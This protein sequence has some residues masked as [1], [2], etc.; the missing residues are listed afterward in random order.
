MNE[1]LVS[2]VIPTFNSEQYISECIDSV[3][4]QTHH[5]LEIIIVDDGS[6]DNTVNIVSDYK[7]DKIKF[8]SQINSGSAAA[9]NYGVLQATGIWLAFIDSDDIWLP[10]KLQKQLEFCSNQLWSHTDLY[11]LGDVYPEHTRT[12]Q[13]TEK[14]SGMIFENLLVEN[15]IATSCVLIKKEIF[16]EFGGFN[17]NYRAL[18][19]WDLWL[20]VSAKY[21]VCYHDEPLVY[22]RV[23][24]GSV[25][26][27]A[28][29]T[30]P[31]HLAL[32]NRVFS[33]Q[34]TTLHL[35]QLKNKALSRSCFICSQI[36]EQEEDYPF[37]CYCAARSLLYQPLNVYRYSRL[38]KIL[39]KTTMFYLSKIFK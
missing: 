34:D 17:T 22:Y 25:S 23:H 31:Y 20:R 18:Q 32:I 6:T 39:L 30:L 26:R 24:S 11:F 1:S 10:E 2:V 15:S 21:E 27:N 36:S 8:F 13:F 37:S 28:R 16:E 19:D 3:L 7:S 33:Q 14:H 35:Q 29:K 38:I 4:D 12:T 9:R 5:N